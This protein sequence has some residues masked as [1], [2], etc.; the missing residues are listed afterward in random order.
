VPGELLDPLMLT[1]SRHTTL[2]QCSQGRAVVADQKGVLTD[3]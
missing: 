1:R 3:D 2:P